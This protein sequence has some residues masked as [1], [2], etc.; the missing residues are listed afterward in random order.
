VGGTRLGG[1]FGDIAESEFFGHFGGRRR[2]LGVVV[3]RQLV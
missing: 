1:V 3:L 2:R